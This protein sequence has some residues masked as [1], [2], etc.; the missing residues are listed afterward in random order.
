MICRVTFI[1]RHVELVQQE[2]FFFGKVL[3]DPEAY[4]E[5]DDGHDRHNQDGDYDRNPQRV[6]AIG[7]HWADTLAVYRKLSVRTL[8]DAS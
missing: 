7:N 4:V 1:L 2:V 3:F 8:Q 5:Y 6:V